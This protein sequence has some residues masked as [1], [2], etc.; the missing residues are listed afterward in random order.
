MIPKETPDKME[1]M[2]SPLYCYDTLTLLKIM[3][4]SD[5]CYETTFVKQKFRQDIFLSVSTALATLLYGGWLPQVNGS[6]RILF[7][8]HR[9]SLFI[10]PS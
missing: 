9:G 4:L 7:V 2:F 8:F 5:T 10:V 3:S 1:E 6:P